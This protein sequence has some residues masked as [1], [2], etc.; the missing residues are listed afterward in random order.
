MM[1]A[2]LLV[3]GGHRRSA[4]RHRRAR[5]PDGQPGST[6]AFGI[7]VPMFGIGLNGLWA[8]TTDVPAP[9]ASGSRR[10]DECRPVGR[11]WTESRHG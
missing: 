2:A 5:G 9:V 10:P 7:L 8:A 4:R 11:P 1:L 3:A 6:L